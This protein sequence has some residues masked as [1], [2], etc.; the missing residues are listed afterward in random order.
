[1]KNK[2]LVKRSQFFVLSPQKIFIFIQ[3]L[4]EKFQQKFSDTSVD[5]DESLARFVVF[6]KWIRSSDKTIKPDAFIP[7][8]YEDLSVTRH[9]QPNN[10]SERELWE[11]GQ[12]VANSRKS[13]LYG[14]ADIRAIT[15][16]Q[17]KL[18]VIPK[19]VKGNPNHANIIHWPNDKALQKIIAQKIAAVA[20]YLPKP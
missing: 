16:R 4:K 14:R 6:S 19:R 10:L 2:D 7:H 20:Q 9:A 11:I 18:D 12:D 8:P 17:Q 15:V 3:S 5:S 13:T 1:M